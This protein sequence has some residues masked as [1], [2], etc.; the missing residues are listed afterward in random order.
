MLKA[1]TSGKAGRISIPGSDASFSW[2]EAFRQ[3]EDL[4]TAVFFGRLRFLSDERLTQVLGLLIG[5][6]A[7]NGLGKFEEMEFW[8]HLSGLKDRS[9]V[10]PDVLLH[11]E[12]ATL[13]V[14]VK[15]PFGAGQYLEQ[16]LAEVHAFVAECANGVREVPKVVHFVALGRIGCSIGK[17]PASEF[18][19]QDCFQ[20]S[21]HAQEW[22]S[23]VAA[24]PEWSVECSRADAAV[25][26]DWANVFTLFNLHVLRAQ[27]HWADLLA[28]NHTLPLSPVILSLMNEVGDNSFMP[29]TESEPREWQSLLVFARNHPL[30][31]N[32]WK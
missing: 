14:E 26:E 6:D 13:I 19:T 1:V 9:W 30:E 27:L 21:V 8:P 5:E 29:T 4:L 2:R 31:P 18:D 24:L 28:F 7:A 17:Q 25:F 3:R 20:L 23:I 12:N 10:E 15:P 32:T 16:W 11:F 22:E